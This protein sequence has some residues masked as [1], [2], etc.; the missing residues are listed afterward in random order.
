MYNEAFMNIQSIVIKE[1]FGNRL[2]VYQVLNALH[3]CLHMFIAIL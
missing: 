2:L 1:T 3:I